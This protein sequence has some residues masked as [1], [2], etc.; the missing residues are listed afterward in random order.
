MEDETAFD[1]L[2]D[3][4]QILAKAQAPM[5]ILDVLRHS[6]LTALLKPNAKVRGIASGDA[7]R[8]LVTK[9]LARQ[10]QEELRNA[11]FPTMLAFATGAGQ[12]RP[13]IFSGI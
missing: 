11:V 12:I 9:A 1:C 6:A 2:F 7:F 8:R 13:Y 3:V 4:A 10:Y 5:L